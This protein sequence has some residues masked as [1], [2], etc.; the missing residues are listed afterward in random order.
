MDKPTFKQRLSY[1][2]DNLMASGTPALVFT[3][4]ILSLIAVCLTASIV[5][6]F[7]LS[8]KGESFGKVVW[9][10]LLRTLDP[11]TMGD[12][13][14][15][16]AFLA[17]MLF[18]TLVGLFLVSALIGVISSEIDTQ[19]ERLRKGRSRVLESGHTVILGWSPQIFTILR[20]LLIANENQKKAKIVLLAERD[21]VAMEDE[22][23]ERI[24]HRHKKRIICRSG[25]PLEPHDLEIVNPKDARSIIVLPPLDSPDVYVIKAVLAIVHHENR[26]KSPYHIVSQIRDPKNLEILRL[27]SKG[28]RMQ[29]ILMDDLIARLMAQTSRQSGLSVVYSEL[30]DFEGDEIYP[31]L[32]PSLYGKTYGDALFA[33]ET[34]SVIGIQKRDAILINPPMDTRIEEGDAI[35]AISEDD[36]TVLPDAPPAP[37][38]QAD[39]IVENGAPPPPKPERSLLLG[40]NRCAE[41][42]IHELDSYVAPG[43]LVT[44]VTAQPLEEKCRACLDS[45]KN[46]E[47][48]FQIGDQ[49]DRAVLDSLNPSSYD[50]ILVLSNDSLSVQEADARTLVTLLHLRDIAERDKTPF[51]IVSEMLDVRNRNLAEITRVDDFIV[52]DHLVSLM[53]AQLS[54]N[55]EMHE[56]FQSLFS[57]EGSEIYLK[58]I[59]EYVQPGIPVTFY[60]LV[61]AARRRGETAIGYRRIHDKGDKMHGVILN[62]RKSEEISFHEDDKL[63]VLAEE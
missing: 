9:N 43:S 62:P 1:W 18:I 6:G 49:T 61:E 34:S 60:T 55:P 40:W 25:S 52:S 24:H 31:Q 53:L 42:A 13:E 29:P 27:A 45:L 8:P 47:V 44:V 41:I 19:L 11:G 56:I 48:R 3:L 28:D 50:H 26:K 16:P 63:I 4:V 12:D 33:Y 23:R 21:K 10:S 59:R 5:A 54:E 37:R 35:L 20:E 15:S 14:G 17:M 32:E 46:Q 38:I 36:D 7:H 57:P 39:A 30:L 2:R 58:P 22:I 51:S